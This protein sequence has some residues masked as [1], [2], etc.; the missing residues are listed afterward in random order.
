MA[1]LASNFVAAFKQDDTYFSRLD[2]TKQKADFLKAGPHEITS[3]TQAYGLLRKDPIMNQG[4]GQMLAEQNRQS[5][6]AKANQANNTGSPF[7][8]TAWVN[9][10]LQQ[11][12]YQNLINQQRSGRSRYSYR[13]MSIPFLLFVGVVFL[14]VYK[15][16]K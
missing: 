11:S 5:E 9:T 15:K 14:V 7:I 6:Q 1:S 16:L 13:Y 8:A 3:G 12:N 4:F 2:N 10:Y